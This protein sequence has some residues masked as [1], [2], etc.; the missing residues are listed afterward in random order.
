MRWLTTFFFPETSAAAA[1]R[2]IFDGRL[3]RR[4]GAPA[5]KRPHYGARKLT[6]RPPP[7]PARAGKPVGEF[8][9]SAWPASL[10]VQAGHDHQLD[11]VGGGACTDLPREYREWQET[12]CQRKGGGSVA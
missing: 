9:E 1:R 2:R 6:Q 11:C 5:H 10:F 4:P 3:S 7:T 8:N 12:L